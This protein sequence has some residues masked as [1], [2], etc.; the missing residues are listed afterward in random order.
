MVSPT[1]ESHGGSTLFIHV[2]DGSVSFATVCDFLELNAFS[3]VDPSPELHASAK[4]WLSSEIPFAITR[5]AH[6][7]R[8]REKKK[9]KRKKQPFRVIGQVRAPDS[10]LLLL[11][12]KHKTLHIS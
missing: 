10:L 1:Q 2:T 9:N 7:E 8:G 3:A 5:P 4:G 11:W 12:D 6:H